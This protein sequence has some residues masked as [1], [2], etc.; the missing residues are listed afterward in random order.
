[1]ITLCHLE[2]QSRRYFYFLKVKNGLHFQTNFMLYVRSSRAS[3]HWYNTLDS[4]NIQKRQLNTL[5]VFWVELGNALLSFLNI[6]KRSDVKFFKEKNHFY[7]L[8]SYHKQ[9]KDNIQTG[10]CMHC[11][12]CLVHKC[13]NS[14]CVLLTSDEQNA[15]APSKTLW[16]YESRNCSTLP[17]H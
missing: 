10:N 4:S 5:R 15:S 7:H 3:S 13:C 16:L 12:Y 17:Q 14:C 9:N 8:K 1:M 11:T 2:T 6:K